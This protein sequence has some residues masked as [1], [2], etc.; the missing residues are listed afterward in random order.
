M[1]YFF[2]SFILILKSG[3]KMPWLFMFMYGLNVST[4]I[5][6]LLLMFWPWP[7]A[8]Y[9]LN[10]ESLNY[11]EFWLSGLGPLFLIASCS[12]SYLCLATAKGLAWSRWGNLFYWSAIFVLFGYGSLIGLFISSILVFALWYYF[13]K[14]SGV[15]SYYRSFGVNNA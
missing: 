4:Y 15:N 2:N 10:G 6:L 9:K 5:P 7:S 11:A 3:K 12:V 1:K 14:S 8:T 13:F